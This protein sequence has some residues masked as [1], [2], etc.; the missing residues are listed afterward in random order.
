MTIPT[1]IGK[2]TIDSQLASSAVGMHRYSAVD[3]SVMHE[4]ELWV[5]SD[6]SATFREELL[7]WARRFATTAHLHLIPVIDVIPT[8]DGHY[9]MVTHSVPGAN[10]FETCGGSGLPIDECVRIVAATASALDHVHAKG[11][12]HGSIC[13]FCI[14]SEHERPNVYLTDFSIVPLDRGV[15][16]YA[17]PQRLKLETGPDT[18]SDIY[19]LGMCFHHALTGKQP[20][21]G[22]S[23]EVLEQAAS[24]SPVSPRRQN[25]SIPLELERICLK[26]IAINPQGR[27]A[28][29]G[30]MVADL[31]KWKSSKA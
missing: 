13:P 22:S 14:L 21:E 2:Y 19:S 25:P 29:A 31:R 16:A 12:T 26:A 4:V 17:S 27:Y 23:L 3:R 1:K 6:R 15:P 24:G 30:E 5:F 28:T 7:N 20:F 11:I 9:C 18:T 8:E 10:L